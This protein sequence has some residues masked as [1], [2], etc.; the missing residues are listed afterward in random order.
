MEVDFCGLKFKNPFCLSSSPVANT[1]EMIARAFEAG[2]GGVVYKTLNLERDYKIV[3]PTPRLNAL[4]HGAQRF[5]GL[6]NIEMVSERPLAA[7]LKDIAWLKK[8]YPDRRL[9]V[10]IMGYSDAGWRELARGAQDAGADMLELNFS[11]P[12][13]AVE[14]AGHKIGQAYDMLE[15]YT[16]VVKE[17]VA[18]PV[19]P[20]MTPNITD[21][22]P[23][24]LA[25]KRGGADAISAINTLR[26]ITEVNLETF[27]PMPTIQGRGSISGYS[28]PAVKP[29]ALRFVAE[30]AQSKE[31]GLPVSGIGGIETWSDA[32]MFFL[33]GAANVQVTTGVMHYGYRIIESLCEG[34][35]DYLETRAFR[36]V[37]DLVGVGLKFTVDPA[38]HHQ[39]KHVVSQVDRDKCVGCGW[40]HVVCHDGA[41]QAM[42]FDGSTRKTEV[43]EERCVGCLLCKHVC[44]VWDCITTVEKDTVVVGGMHPDALAFVQ[45]D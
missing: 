15:R 1:A 18:I 22:V 21:M 45:H 30:L 28:G 23:A 6:Q 25:C 7:N 43:D 8:H 34:L 31:L 16:R 38:E 29:I 39:T 42:R 33:L 2:W 20:K 12:Q 41:N 3:D 4:H 35:E 5:V 14:G 27:A 17:S 9:I 10:S 44:P 40:C 13:M 24:A 19:M 26:A 36:C 32:A 37:A 11:C